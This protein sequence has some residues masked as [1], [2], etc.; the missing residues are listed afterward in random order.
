MSNSFR[1]LNRKLRSA[2]SMMIPD[3]QIELMK[4]GNICALIK[5]KPDGLECSNRLYKRLLPDMRSDFQHLV[6]YV[7][8][9]VISTAKYW[10]IR[11]GKGQCKRG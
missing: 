6:D 2:K 9:E 11:Q 8:G 7:K 4:Q 1:N 5:L 3:V 10:E